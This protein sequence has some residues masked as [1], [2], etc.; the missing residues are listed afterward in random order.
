MTRAR[1]PAT[2]LRR[3]DS[4]QALLGIGMRMRRRDFGA[5][6][7]GWGKNWLP[8]RAD[9]ALHHYRPRLMKQS[10]SRERLIPDVMAAAAAL[11]GTD[12]HRR[13]SA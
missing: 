7:S 5:R 12:V 8:T 9:T 3:T 1:G 4:D 10:M 13:H 11:S 2:A 6:L